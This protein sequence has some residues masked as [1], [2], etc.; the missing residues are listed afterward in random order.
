MKI[1]TLNWDDI[2]RSVKKDLFDKGEFPSDHTIIWGKEG[3]EAYETFYGAVVCSKHGVMCDFCGADGAKPKKN[4]QFL[5][6]RHSFDKRK[7]GYEV[8]KTK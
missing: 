1:T 5:G 6:I 8:I 4:E 2:V 3:T 7:N